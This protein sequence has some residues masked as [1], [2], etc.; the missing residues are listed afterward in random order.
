[1]NRTKFSVLD[2]KKTLF[3][4]DLSDGTGTLA[5]NPKVFNNDEFKSSIRRANVHLEKNYDFMLFDESKK[6]IFQREDLQEKPKANKHAG[7]EEE[8]ISFTL[9]DPGDIVPSNLNYHGK[10]DNE[11]LFQSKFTHK[12]SNYGVNN[13]V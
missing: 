9:T 7:N 3:K 4:S 10:I 2:N 1:M 8:P 6:D 11:N 5:S 12:E 13:I